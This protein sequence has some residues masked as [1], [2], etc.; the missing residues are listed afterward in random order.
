M[1]RIAQYVL[2]GFI[3]FVVSAGASSPRASGHCCTE[4]RAGR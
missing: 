3:T 1:R 4:A 2:I